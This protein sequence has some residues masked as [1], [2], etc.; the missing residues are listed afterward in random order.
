ME[1]IHFFMNKIIQIKINISS[2]RLRT[3]CDIET[4]GFRTAVKTAIVVVG[5]AVSRW[6]LRTNVLDVTGADDWSTTA[7]MR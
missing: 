6:T 2:I 3:E 7:L 1:D 5:V 4:G